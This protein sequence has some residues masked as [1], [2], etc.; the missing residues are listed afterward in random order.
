M[1][2]SRHDTAFFQ[3]SYTSGSS[4]GITLQVTLTY[5]SFFIALF[6]SALPYFLPLFCHYEISIPG[7]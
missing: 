5:T 7:N 3:R 4:H 1:I 2:K 6:I